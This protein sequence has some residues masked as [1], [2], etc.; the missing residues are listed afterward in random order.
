MCTDIAFI[1]DS[2][3]GSTT[4]EVQANKIQ[5]RDEWSK[6]IADSVDSMLTSKLQT[7]MVQVEDRYINAPEN[8]ASNDRMKAFEEKVEVISD[9]KK[10]MSCMP[11]TTIPGIDDVQVDGGSLASADYNSALSAKLTSKSNCKSSDPEMDNYSDRPYHSEGIE[12]VRYAD[13]GTEGMPS[14]MDMKNLAMSND[15]A[16]TFMLDEE[17]ELE[18]KIIKDDR[19]PIRRY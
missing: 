2:L 16:N 6:W 10:L 3:L 14:D 17:P 9:G 4:V 11:S 15:F 7:H 1:I 12:T 5:R 13:D 18:Q 8:S 19:S